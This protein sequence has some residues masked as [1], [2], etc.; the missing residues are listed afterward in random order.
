MQNAEKM[1]NLWYDVG[2][3]DTCSLND[4]KKVVDTY[5]QVEW[6]Y[7][8]ERKGDVRHT[9]IGAQRLQTTGWVPKV[10]LQTG[11][12]ECFTKSK[13]IKFFP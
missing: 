5:N 2:Y 10:D 6:V 3:G 12:K 8:P 1:D 13:K 9:E 4:I 7:G 11:L